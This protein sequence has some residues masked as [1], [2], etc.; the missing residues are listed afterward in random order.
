[1]KW[2]CT[3]KSRGGNRKKL[4]KGINKLAL[5]TLTDVLSFVMGKNVVFHVQEI[6]TV[7]LYASLRNLSVEGSS[8]ELLS[9][10]EDEICSPD[11][12]QR[13]VQQKS[14]K[15][16]I[17]DFK[18]AQQRIYHVLRKM[19]FLFTRVTVAID[20]TDKLYYGDE[21]RATPLIHSFYINQ[22]E[23]VL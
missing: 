22:E 1:M 14:E 11:V 17:E 20:C 4:L 5:S 8:E 9:L 10:S 13:R 18:H 23:K 19:R 21:I 6:L 16:I 3:M 15:E 2:E 12:V 7:V